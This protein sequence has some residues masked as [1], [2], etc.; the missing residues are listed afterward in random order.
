MHSSVKRYQIEMNVMNAKFSPNDSELNEE[1]TGVFRFFL[2]WLCCPFT[3]H[4][5]LYVMRLANL[6]N[7]RCQI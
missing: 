4:S 1:T 7:G 6:W 2:A 3:I 5:T